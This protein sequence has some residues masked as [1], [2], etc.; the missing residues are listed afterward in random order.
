MRRNLRFFSGLAVL[1]PWTAQSH[2]T[3]RIHSLPYLAHDAMTEHP[4]GIYMTVENVWTLSCCGPFAL[5]TMFH[6]T[7]CSCATALKPGLSLLL[8]LRSDQRVHQ[9]TAGR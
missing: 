8:S 3:A 2:F 6:P 5:D 7:Y 1:V 4:G 9:P